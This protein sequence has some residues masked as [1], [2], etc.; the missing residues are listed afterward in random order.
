MVRG[1]VG[2]ATKQVLVI[3]AHMQGFL[4]WILQVLC[5]CLILVPN[6]FFFLK[7]FLTSG[8]HQLM[9]QQCFQ[10]LPSTLACLNPECAFEASLLIIPIYCAFAWIMDQS[11]SAWTGGS[12]PGNLK[13]WRP[14][15]QLTWTLA[16][17]MQAAVQRTLL[18]L[19]QSTPASLKHLWCG[20]G[21]FNTIWITPES[22]SSRATTQNQAHVG[23]L[24]TGDFRPGGRGRGLGLGEEP[25]PSKQDGHNSL[26]PQGATATNLSICRHS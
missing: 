12:L 18:Q 8:Y 3:S 15:D 13:Q 1:G 20:D 7:S 6:I 17:T 9:W 2:R 25:C 4:A 26:W 24:P 14:P 5:I 16:T 11:G 23:L 10:C 19:A 21:V 22:H